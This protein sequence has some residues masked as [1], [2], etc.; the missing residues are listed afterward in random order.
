MTREDIMQCRDDLWE[1]ESDICRRDVLNLI[2]SGEEE[3]L[4]CQDAV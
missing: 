4:I 2:L 1:E 3:N